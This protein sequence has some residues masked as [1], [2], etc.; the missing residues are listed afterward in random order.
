ML[1]GHD[2]NQTAVVRAGGIQAVVLGME[3]HGSRPSTINPRLSP[4]APQPSPLNT[5]PSTSTLD[6]HHSTT[7][8][9]PSPTLNARLS[10]QV[11]RECAESGTQPP[12]TRPAP[13]NHHPPSTR[14]SPLNH[15]RPSPLNH[16]PSTLTHPQPHRS[17]ARVQSQ[18]CLALRTL[19][20]LDQNKPAIVRAGKP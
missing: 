18:G 15:H 5:H 8:P 2:A 6:L 13:L 17:V 7:T 4:L 9:Q 12:S 10:T 11:G 3:A 16:H 14:P 19:A 1:A 20:L